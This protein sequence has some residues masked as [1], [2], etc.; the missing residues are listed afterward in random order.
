MILLELNDVSL[1]KLLYSPDLLT[2]LVSKKLA[3]YK[4]LTFRAWEKEVLGEWVF[5]PWHLCWALLRIVLWRDIE[6]AV[7]C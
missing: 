4:C 1:Y 6:G 2:V 5:L 3:C 7:V